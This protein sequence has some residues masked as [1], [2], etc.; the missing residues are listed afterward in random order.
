MAS[1]LN[2][3]NPSGIDRIWPWFSSLAARSVPDRGSSALTLWRERTLVIV[4]WAMAGFGLINYIPS[5]IA[6]AQREQW[7]IVATYSFSFLLLLTLIFLKKADY[8]LRAG[9]TVGLVLA[10]GVSNIYTIGNFGSGKIILFL[11][12][13]LSAIFFGLRYGF[14][15]VGL[16]LL[17]MA[18]LTLIIG[19]KLPAWQTLIKTSSLETNWVLASISMAILSSLGIAALGVVV[20]GLVQSLQTSDRL[21][22]RLEQ[23]IA[24]REMV[25]AKLRESEQRF[26]TMAEFF[27]LPTLILSPDEE[28][29]FVSE[30][31]TRAFGWRRA[32]I[33]TFEAWLRAAYP[34]NREFEKVLTEA[35]AWLKSVGS[36]IRTGES[37]TTTAR[38]EIRI[39]QFRATHM[40]GGDITYV[41][42]DI[43]DLRRIETELRT[44]RDQ[45]RTFM[46]NLP[47]YAYIKD[48]EG[49]YAYVNKSF[50]EIENV[51]S[52]RVLGRTDADIFPPRVAEVR[53]ANDR[54]VLAEGRP[55]EGIE[56][57]TRGERTRYYLSQKFPLPEADGLCR[58]GGM[59]FDVTGLKRTEAELRRSE[60]RLKNIIDN[61]AVG[62]YRI[63]KDGRFRMVNGR[64]AR[65]LGF[66]DPEA[67]LAARSNIIECYA[68]PSLRQKMIDRF[69]KVGR[70]QGETIE[71]IAKDGSPVWVKVDARLDM[72]RD[73]EEIFEGFIEDITDR[74]RAR[75]ALRES[76]ETFD[77]FMA[78]LP[79]AAFIKDL[80]GKYLYI[81]QAYETLVGM[82][83]DQIL[84]RSGDHKWD[85]AT[86]TRVRKTDRQVIARGEPV[87]YLEVAEN[88]R[89]ECEH[90]LYTKFPVIISGS[91]AS[92]G[93]FAFDVTDQIKAEVALRESEEK[94][95]HLAE[96]ANDMIYR[97]SLP[98]GRYEY[99][100]P[101]AEALFGYPP[102]D[103]YDSPV[104]I[105][106]VIHPDWA[107]YIERQWADLLQGRMPPFYEY[108]IIHK[109]GEVK[110]LNQ[111]NALIRDDRGRPLAIQGIV[112]DIT[113]RKLTEE[114]LKESEARLSSLSDA[115]FEAIFFSDQGIIIDQ[116]RTAE[117]MYGYTRE[118]AIGSPSADRVIPEDRELVN[119]SILSGS[120][121]PYEVT[122]LRKDGTTFPAEIQARMV[123]RPGHQ[124]RI[125]ALRDITERRAMEEQRE[126]T[127]AELQAALAE[128][129][130]LRGFLPICSSC[131]KIRD[132]A[133]YWLQVE[134]YIED[135]T[136]ARF[137]H[138][139]CPECYLKLYPDLVED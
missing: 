43:S 72:E 53:R 39:V 132:D 130:E 86:M 34:D 73:G 52:E 48:G 117:E 77:S 106:K 56:E 37:R 29:T 128:I 135:R 47:G 8:R 69:E 23:D 13:M 15:A 28:V 89:N 94:F 78:N 50:M 138:S 87:Q 70:I 67:L 81:N 82:S 18:S 116:N 97:M 45:F 136:D 7:L 19:E 51:D 125:T 134:E 21:S 131:K 38:G 74:I 88:S 133:G 83:E 64:Y 112:T 40:P 26:K 119:R 98:D 121:K 110:W 44:S 71:V 92:I 114:A 118:E 129:K 3:E 115:S 62:I 79:A 126:R 102:Q 49:R 30:S 14:L 127:I 101:A 120:E 108:Q 95:R 109:S 24:E 60:E 123:S 96:I 11:F 9:L 20:K 122:A 103:F 139:I 75:E 12:A 36:E 111:R 59:S 27:P 91:V 16:N 31:F 5:A 25:L 113:P 4:L 54:L 104:L 66:E 46:D 61:A 2:P 100:S 33:P 105:K 137:S 6:F 107:E 41:I 58:I 90:L 68:D 99:V 124:I 65:I 55:F 63:T 84:G 35:R 76:E 93:G 10:V 32:D 57:L 1:D 85:P 42:N 22:A 17:I 80:D